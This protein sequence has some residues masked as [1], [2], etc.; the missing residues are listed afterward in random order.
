MK[1]GDLVIPKDKGW[2]KYRKSIGIVVE[3]SSEPVPLLLVHWFCEVPIQNEWGPDHL[4][5]I[6]ESR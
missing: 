1:A 5:V 6:N 4:E 3:H 2:R